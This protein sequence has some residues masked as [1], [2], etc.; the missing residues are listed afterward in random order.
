MS[1]S[2]AFGQTLDKFQAVRHK[3]AEMAR[4]VEM[5]KEFN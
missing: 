1:E 3:I 2:Q 4:E 5:C